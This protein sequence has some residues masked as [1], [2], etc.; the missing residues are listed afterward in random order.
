MDARATAKKL[1]TFNLFF[2]KQTTDVPGPLPAY[3]VPGKQDALL[4]EL[5]GQPVAVSFPVV[6]ALA[7]SS[8][9]LEQEA[10]AQDPLLPPPRRAPANKERGVSEG[11]GVGG[12]ASTATCASTP[13]PFPKVK[14]Y[15]LFK[16]HGFAIAGAGAL[17][18]DQAVAGKGD[19]LHGGRRGGGG[20]LVALKGAGRGRAV[21]FDAEGGRAVGV[22]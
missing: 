2:Q 11:Q 21:Q 16:V 5:V 7:P 14:S 19:V 13:I 15:L 17:G 9:V 4:H 18:T 6:L 22:A 3:V 20:T 10:V 8:L 12:M 1:H